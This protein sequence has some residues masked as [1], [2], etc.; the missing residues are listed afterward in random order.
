MNVDQQ[1]QVLGED[2]KRWKK[3]KEGK[4]LQRVPGG[5]GTLQC[6]INFF[7]ELFECTND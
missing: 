2:L 1:D 5:P 7:L 3:P 6:E 4:L